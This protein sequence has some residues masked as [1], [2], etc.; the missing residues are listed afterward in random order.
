MNKINAYRI[1]LVDYLRSK[2]TYAHLLKCVIENCDGG[3]GREYRGHV[4]NVLHRDGDHE[5]GQIAG[6]VVRFCVGIL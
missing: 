3:H 2:R 5:A 1:K 4:L 6:I